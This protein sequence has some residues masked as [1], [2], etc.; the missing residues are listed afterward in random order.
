M[1]SCQVH[2]VHLPGPGDALLAPG[3]DG[4]NTAGHAIRLPVCGKKAS[5][6]FSTEE[7]EATSNGSCVRSGPLAD[8]FNFPCLCFLPAHFL[9]A[10]ICP[11]SSSN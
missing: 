2:N 6:Q 10:L 4:H 11:S 8:W 7:E 1:Y 9:S 3:A 5:G